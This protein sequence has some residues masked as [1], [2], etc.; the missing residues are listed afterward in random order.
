ME[1]RPYAAIRSMIMKLGEEDIYRPIFVI[2]NAGAS[3]N[4]MEE[5]NRV[6]VDCSGQTLQ[7]LRS[8]NKVV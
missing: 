7:L 5:L 3:F 1:F 4:M 8:V 2:V 6:A